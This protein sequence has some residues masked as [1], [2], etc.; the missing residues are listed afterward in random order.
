MGV[1]LKEN[2][3]NTSAA[4]TIGIG[5]AGLETSPCGRAEKRR[6][7]FVFDTTRKANPSALVEQA[8][9]GQWHS[10]R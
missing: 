1:S 7:V 6:A 2:D 9:H 3:F 8:A 5:E 10:D 4:I